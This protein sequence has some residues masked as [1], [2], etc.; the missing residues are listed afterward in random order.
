MIWVAPATKVD[1]PLWAKGVVLESGGT[2]YVLCVVDWCGIGG[3]LNTLFRRQI[4]AAAG[5]GIEHVLVH[6]VHQHTA[7]YAEGDGY[8][9]LGKLSVPQS[10]RLSDGFV[11]RVTNRIASAVKRASGNLQAFDRVGYGEAR[12]ERVA[13]ARRVILDGKLTTRWSSTANSPALAA[14]PEGPIDPFLRTVTFAAGDKPLVRLHYYATHPQTFCC[15]GTVTG[16]FVGAAREAVEKS[17]GVPQIYF[18]GCAGDV[19]AGKY[20]DNTAAAREGLAHRMEAGLRASIAATRLA[21]AGRVGWRTVELTLPKRTEVRAKDEAELAALAKSGKADATA[22]YR[23]AITTAFLL[24]KRPLELTALSLGDLRILHLPG[25]P[26][27]EFQNYARGLRP[28]KFV[29]VA[30][31]GDVAPGYLCPDRA[32]EEGGY[33]PSASNA[34]L[35]TEAALKKG[36]RDLLT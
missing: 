1:D 26:L 27:L 12:V 29:A 6:S 22:L 17:E 25:E 10:T 16:D 20:N 31:Y 7:P 9:L 30:G 34:G 28:G 23:A 8:A 2:R 21:P 35:G 15:N 3:A 14:L 36:I 32:I 24:R 5:T 19:T 13:S 11:E 18:T 33:E 4:A